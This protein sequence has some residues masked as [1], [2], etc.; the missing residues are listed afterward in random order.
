[1]QTV[2][3]IQ[4]AR[5]EFLND[6]IKNEQT[7]RDWHYERIAQCDKRIEELAA[8]RDEIIDRQHA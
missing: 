2:E 8:L 6:C 1:M 3:E 5:I 7:G 4:A